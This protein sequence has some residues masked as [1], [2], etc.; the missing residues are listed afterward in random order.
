MANDVLIVLLQSRTLILRE[1]ELSLGILKVDFELG[2]FQLQL[3]LELTE[4][5]INTLFGEGSRDGRV[6]LRG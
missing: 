2:V 4:P 3:L 1:Q 5:L 6:A